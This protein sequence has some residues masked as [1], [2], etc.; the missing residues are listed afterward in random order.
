MIPRLDVRS[1]A[2]RKI[3]TGE[4]SFEYEAEDALLDIPFVR[5]S[6]PVRVRLDYEIFEDNTVEAKARLSFSLAGSCSRCL[7]ETERA[8]EEEAVGI[9]EPDGGDG[10]TYGYRNGVVELNEFIRDSVLSALP[11]RLLCGECGIPD[12][13]QE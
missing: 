12:R 8:F 11:P 9:F 6:S 7:G 5:F 1:L 13:E 4:L 2:A 3:Y 10:E